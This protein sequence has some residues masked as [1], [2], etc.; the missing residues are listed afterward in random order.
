LVAVG[1]FSSDAVIFVVA[2]AAGGF[3]Q[4]FLQHQL[5]AR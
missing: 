3:L 1:S 5:A 4:H 2:M